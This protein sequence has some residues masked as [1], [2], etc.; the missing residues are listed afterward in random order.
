MV[1]TMD[2]IEEAIKTGQFK[3]IYVLCGDEDYLKRQYLHK[4]LSVLVK[5]KD[6]M[7]YTH[8]DGEEVTAG[9]IID[10][11]ETLPFFAEH[12]VIQIDNSGFFKKS[13]ET[14]A[15][16]MGTIPDT[17]CIIFIENET[18]KRT[19]TYKAALKYGEICE[20]HLPGEGILWQWLSIRL[21]KVSLKMTKDAW[22]EFLIRTGSSMENMDKEIEKVIAYCFGKEEITKEDIEQVCTGQ[23]EARV[24]D[25]ISAIAAK[26]TQEVMRLYRDLLATKEPPLRVLAL[27]ERQ[28]RQMLSIRG[29]YDRHMDGRTI[30]KNAGMPDFAVRKNYA[31]S[32]NFTKETMQ[33]LLEDAAEYEKSIK[34]GKILDQMG[35]ELLMLQYAK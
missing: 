31:L 19:K 28:F 13:E 10:L 24:F 11:A 34:S 2:A 26:N 14:L 12:R 3:K 29:M 33:K 7:N 18:D 22:K 25:M 21:K 20:Y 4:L 35:V 9:Q 16:Y 15:E 32:R 6:T 23:A 30:A 1:K 8:F 27:I 5:E 17:T